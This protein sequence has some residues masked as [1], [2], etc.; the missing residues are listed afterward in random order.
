MCYEI[1]FENTVA[2]QPSTYVGLFTGS[3][4]ERFC[5]IDPTTNLNIMIYVI[6]SR[7]ISFFRLNS[8]IIK[9][10]IPIKG[11]IFVTTPFTLRTYHQRN[12]FF[13]SAVVMLVECVILIDI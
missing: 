6:L 13:H 4:S 3:I 11:V 9:I 8:R 12:K 2:D 10:Y 7:E 1:F 5:G